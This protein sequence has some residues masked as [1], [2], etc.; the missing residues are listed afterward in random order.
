[1]D[2]V[3][4]GMMVAIKALISPTAARTQKRA[5]RGAGDD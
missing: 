3:R 2:C 5:E 4:A 1:M